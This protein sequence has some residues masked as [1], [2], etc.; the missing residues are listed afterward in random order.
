MEFTTYSVALAAALEVSGYPVR[1]I[2][3]NA[4]GKLAFVFDR[5][6]EMGAIIDGYWADTLALP[7]RS[8][9]KR[10]AGLR[11]ALMAAKYGPRG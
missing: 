1:E 6:P 11:E 9:A 4:A 7:V 5:T 8:Y 3:R 2:Q 10:N